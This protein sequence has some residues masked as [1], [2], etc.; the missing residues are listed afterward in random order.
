MLLIQIFQCAFDTA[1]VTLNSR[2]NRRQQINVSES[3][4]QIDSTSYTEGTYTV[5]NTTTNT[6]EL[7][8]E[9]ERHKNVTSFSSHQIKHT[10]LVLLNVKGCLVLKLL[11]NHLT[12]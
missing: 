5:K 2:F 8:S 7:F 3:L 4:F 6:F 1:V 9:D 12:L 11:D 10:T